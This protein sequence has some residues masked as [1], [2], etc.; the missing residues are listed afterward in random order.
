MAK[1]ESLTPEQIAKF[2]E[3]VDH[4]IKVG[5]D[6]KRMDK[7]L[8]KVLCAKA[9]EAAGK[10]PP[11]EYFFFESPMSAMIGVNA[12]W[13]AKEKKIALKDLTMKDMEEVNK[14]G[15]FSTCCEG[16]QEAGWMA[17]Y[18]FF[19]NEC[20]LVE[21]TEKTEPLINLNCEV[22]WWWC[23]DD[24]VFFSEKPTI[25]KL[26]NRQLHCEDGPAIAYSDGLKIYSIGGVTVPEYVVMNPEQIT[27]Q[28]INDETNMEIKRIMTDRYG[29]SRYLTDVGAKVIEMEMIKVDQTDEDS[30]S[31]PRSLMRCPDGRQFLCG[32]DGST[33]RVYYMNVDP[34][35]T[36]CSEAHK[37]ISDIDESDIICNS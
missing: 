22:G 19:R 5:T 30:D 35:A 8:V 18:R 28:K 2:D 24:V 20:G 21:E 14:L 25:C 17:F 4:W 29:I 13:Y 16:N 34:D 6:T 11:T 10:K 15:N 23:Y 3:Y 36:T 27:I 37:S 32:T 31:M 9:Y 33:H 7:A 12:Y 26:E 1:I